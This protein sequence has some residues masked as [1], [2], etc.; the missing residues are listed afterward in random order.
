MRTIRRDPQS[1]V[2][3]TTQAG[4]DLC[5]LQIVLEGEIPHVPSLHALLITQLFVCVDIVPYNLGAELPVKKASGNLSFFVSILFRRPTAQFSEG[6]TDE[7]LSSVSLARLKT[8]LHD[9]RSLC[10]ACFRRYVRVQCSRDHKNEDADRTVSPE[11]LSFASHCAW[12]P[13]RHRKT[14][15]SS[16]T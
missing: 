10:L 4:G 2:I 16:G 7:V 3:R 14:E 1:S 13:G 11:F 5:R 15:V 6:R 9:P 12:R 8:C